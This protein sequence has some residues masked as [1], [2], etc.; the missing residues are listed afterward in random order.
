MSS[1]KSKVDRTEKKIFTMTGDHQEYEAR[2]RVTELNN[3]SSSSNGNLSSNGDLT[4]TKNSEKIETINGHDPGPNRPGT[5]IGSCSFEIIKNT[6]NIDFSLSTIKLTKLN[7]IGGHS[8]IYK[9]QQYVIKELNGEDVV[10]ETINKHY[11]QLCHYLPK[12]EGTVTLKISNDILDYIVLK[13]LT[14]KLQEP[15]VMDLKM[16]TRQYGI[17]SGDKKIASQKL[18]CKNLTS[19][20]LGTRLCGLQIVNENGKFELYD[21]YYGRQLN[22]DRFLGNLLRF[23]NNKKRYHLITKCLMIINELRNISRLIEDLEYF[24]LYGSSIL[25]IY[26]NLDDNVIIKLIDFSKSFI[27]LESEF[28]ELPLKKSKDYGYLKGLFNL[29]NLFEWI[30]ET[31]SGIKLTNSINE[32]LQEIEIRKSEFMDTWKGYV[33]FRHVPYEYDDFVS[34]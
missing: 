20:L 21:K 15:F 19:L 2:R 6:T 8:I 1:R 11:K 30:F 13:D 25:I 28:N 17:K 9:Y 3:K 31:V 26:D 32:I 23:L 10:Y 24:R 4:Y 33:T 34:D 27:V 16:G 22:N 5:A 7:K 29:I 14:Y 12:Y 18:K